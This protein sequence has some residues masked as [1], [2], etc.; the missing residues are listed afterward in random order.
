VIRRGPRRLDDGLVGL[1][2]I[3]PADAGDLFRWRSQAR[4]RQL[5]HSGRAP[6][7]PEHQQFVDAYFASDN[8]DAW[9]V[10]EVG[11]RPA[12]GVAL[13]RSGPLHEW[14]AGRIVLDASL[15]GLAG[16]RYARRA[17]ALLMEFA[18]AVGHRHMRCEVLADNRV[19]LGIVRSLG[20]GENAQGESGGRRFVEL[21]VLLDE[22]NDGTR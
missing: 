14:E 3:E 2:E 7:L 21:V 12:G 22:E 1:R 17:I 6:S 4:V 20:F 10:I 5:F 19:M 11:G 9:F 18:R 13:Y 15:R 8:E 16:F